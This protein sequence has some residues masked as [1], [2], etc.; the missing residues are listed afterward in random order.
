MRVRLFTNGRALLF[1]FNLPM[2]QLEQNKNLLPISIII[3][4][5]IVAAAILYTRAPVSAPAGQQQAAGTV[6]PTAKPVNIKDV[7]VD[8]DPFIGEANA[9]VTIAYW[10]DYQCPFCKQFE[11]NTIT[12]PLMTSM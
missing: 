12:P 1:N 4:G 3:A 2:D 8:S 7:K 5:V 11:L 9:P 6:V 10:S